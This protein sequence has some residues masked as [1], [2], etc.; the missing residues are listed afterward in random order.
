ML[1]ST[2]PPLFLRCFSTHHPFFN[3]CEKRRLRR[4]ESLNFVPRGKR[5]DLGNE[6]GS[7]FGSNIKNKERIAAVLAA[8]NGLILINCYV[9]HVFVTQCFG[10]DMHI[11]FCKY[12][13][14]QRSPPN[15]PNFL[16]KKLRKATQ[17]KP[18][19]SCRLYRIWEPLEENK[20]VP[21][22]GFKFA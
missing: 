6:V 15:Q 7:H 11:T 17:R 5:M 8:Y 4:L 13:F 9:E 14:F 20:R 1:R 18:V 19:L 10:L 16:R 22:D 3:S 21:G 12:R 2:P